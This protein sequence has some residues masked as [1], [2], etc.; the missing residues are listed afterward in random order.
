M[1]A[2]TSLSKA[3]SAQK[4]KNRDAVAKSLKRIEALA[5]LLSLLA[6][7]V[8]YEVVAETA[9]IIV[10]ETESLKNAVKHT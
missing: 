4:L 7:Q 2:A 10:D 8:P 6:D 5:I 3:S 1:P 9:G